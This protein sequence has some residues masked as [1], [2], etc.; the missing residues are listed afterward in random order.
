M[1]FMRQILNFNQWYDLQNSEKKT[2]ENF[3]FIT[4]MTNS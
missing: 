1:E 4:S 2:V 3:S